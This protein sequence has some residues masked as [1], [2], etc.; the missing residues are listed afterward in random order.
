M[1]F[2]I[3]LNG[4]LISSLI[5]LSFPAS[6]YASPP[7]TAPVSGFARSFLTESD[8]ENATITILETGQKL[9]TDSHGQFGPILYPIG[10]PITLLSEKWGYKSTQSSTMIVP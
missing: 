4:M 1:Q 8:I 10:K 5:A 6:S 9:K 7:E 2:R 3:T